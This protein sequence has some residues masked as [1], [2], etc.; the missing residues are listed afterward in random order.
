MSGD[1]VSLAVED[2]S[3]S[4]VSVV[5]MLVELVLCATERVGLDRGGLDKVGFDRV[6]LEGTAF[7]ST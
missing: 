6:G 1:W 2:S 4:M 5:E 7:I 3:L